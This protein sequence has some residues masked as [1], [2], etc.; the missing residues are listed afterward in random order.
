MVGG[1]PSAFS[2]ILLMLLMAC[3]SEGDR[4]ETS[5]DRPSSGA[6]LCV[7]ATEDGPWGRL[8]TRDDEVS[9]ALGSFCWTLDGFG[10]CEDLD[11]I[12][13]LGGSVAISSGSTVAVVEDAQRVSGSVGV[14]RVRDGRRQ[15]A[16]VA[17]LDLS[18][19]SAILRVSPGQ[20]V[21]EVFGRWEQGDAELYFP[22]E[23]T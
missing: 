7:F 5:C 23:V 6:V 20:R 12:P 16:D 18:A 3:T 11:E 15:L 1:R 10:R 14:V 13:E 8:L 17:D 2:L 21:I 19:G 9:G 4:P 22:I